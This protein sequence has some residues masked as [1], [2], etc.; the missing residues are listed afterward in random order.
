MINDLLWKCIVNSSMELMIV[1]NSKGNVVFANKYACQ[2]LGYEDGMEGVSFSDIIPKGTSGGNTD[3]DDLLS[4]DSSIHEMMVYRKNRT[5]F[6]AEVK[7]IDTGDRE[8]PFLIMIVN[9]SG[10][11]SLKKEI[12]QVKQDSSDADKVKNEFVANVTHELRTP[13]NGILGNTNIL[14]DNE[15]EPTKLKILHTI[16]HSCREMNNLINSILDFSKL[17]AGKFTIEYRKFEFRNMIDYVRSTHM[18]K[19]TEKGLEFFVTVSPEVPKFI[20][21]D[22]LR[23]GQILNNLLS[24]ACK[25]THYGKITLEILKT[26]QDKNRMELFFMVVDTGIGIDK[27]DMDKLFKSFSQVD[28][29]VSRKYGGTGLGLNISKQL[30]NMMGGNITVDSVKNKGTMFSFSIWVE[31]PEDEIETV[32]NNVVDFKPGSFQEFA[33]ENG[34]NTSE[35]GSA[36]NLK[37]LELQL[38]KLILCVDMENWEKAENFSESIKQLTAEAPKEVKTTALRL[39]MAV[40]KSDYEKANAAYNQLKTLLE[41]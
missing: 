14:L 37:E 2:E 20:I 5:C 3:L 28:A 11:Y 17:E 39:K 30:V 6:R 36:D 27:G 32:T 4:Y 29:S 9:I 22:E 35:F 1:H 19:I 15:T 34:D 24:N 41:E 16:E 18:P 8:Y 23:I 33:D 7:G 13:V 40:Q 21:G 38:S 10:L 26:A 25:F 12:E 31:I